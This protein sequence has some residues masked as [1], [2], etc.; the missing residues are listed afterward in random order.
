MVKTY[1]LKGGYMTNLTDLATD[2]KNKTQKLKENEKQVTEQI[3]QD[4]QEL[5]RD[6]EKWKSDI[7][8]CLT[9][10]ETSILQDI[11]KQSQ[12][13]EKI[14]STKTNEL[15]AN[16]TTYGAKAFTIGA[17]LWGIVGL[18]SGAVFVIMMVMVWIKNGELNELK[19]EIAY[20]EKTL[21]I[22]EDKT[23][24][25]RITNCNIGTEEKPIYQPCAEIEP[26]FY[27]KKWGGKKADLRILRTSKKGK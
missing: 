12:E 11:S 1:D 20:A 18:I 22:L 13:V 17:I 15:K 9:Q 7:K 14:I 23:N 24:G 27:S 6:C 4:Y 3:E 19:T 10:S 8:Q 2:F 5:M 21:S 25:V 26:V 16:I